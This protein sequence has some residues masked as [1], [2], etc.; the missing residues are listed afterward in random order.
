MLQGFV[1]DK[2][3]WHWELVLK[4][5]LRDFALDELPGHWQFVFDK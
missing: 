3:P 1:L 5:W 4:E 2:L